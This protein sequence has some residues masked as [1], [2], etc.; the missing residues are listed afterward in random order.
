MTLTLW[1]LGIL[2]AEVLL[3]AALWNQHVW[4]WLKRHTWIRLLITAGMS[5]VILLTAG[6]NALSVWGFS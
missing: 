6:V 3:V 2:A 4:V 5:L 1:A